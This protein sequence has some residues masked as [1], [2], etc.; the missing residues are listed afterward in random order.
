MRIRNLT[1]AHIIKNKKKGKI[2][3]NISL[4]SLKKYHGTPYWLIIQSNMEKCIRLTIYPL[5]KKKITKLI[6]TG[7]NI[8]GRKL[9]DLS[10]ILKS[11]EII[12][13]SGILRMGENILYELYLNLSLSE[14]KEKTKNNTLQRIKKIFYDVGVEEI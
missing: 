6:L 3:F 7:K 14:F 5:N 9:D 2:N 4:A 12:H 11:L 10:E 1:D 13:T 8:D